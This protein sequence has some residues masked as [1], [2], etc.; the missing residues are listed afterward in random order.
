[1]RVKMVGSI[2]GTR[3][4]EPWPEVGGEIVLP[5]SEG[6]EL[7]ALGMAVPVAEPEKPETRRGRK[8]PEAGA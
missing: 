5:D 1:M 7:C 3:N 6:A 2:T 4:G 8:G